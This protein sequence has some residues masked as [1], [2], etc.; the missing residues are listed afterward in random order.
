MKFS[1]LP[2]LLKPFVHLGLEDVVIS[3]QEACGTCP[4]CGKSKKFYVN[5]ATGQW[6]CKGGGCARSGNLYT[7]LNDWHEQQLEDSDGWPWES[8]SKNRKLPVEVLQK[9]GLVAVDDAWFVPVYGSSGKIVTYRSFRPDSPLEDLRK[10]RALPGLSLCL[11]GMERLA[12][13]EDANLPVYLCEGEWD[14]IALHDTFQKEGVAAVVVAAP[15][16]SVFKDQWAECFKGREVWLCYDNDT[17][18]EKGHKRAVAALSAY[19]THINRI[20][21]PEACP[22]GYDVRDFLS[23]GASLD[24]FQELFVPEETVAPSKN[25]K[26][27]L[28]DPGRP[29]FSDALAV[30]KKWLYMTPDMVDA[31]RIIYAVVLSNQIDGDPLWIHLAGPPGTGKTELLSS[32][33]EVSSCVLRS[34]VTAHA[35]VSGFKASPDP[36]LIPKLIGKVFML[37]DFTEILN[38]K[39]DS[40]DFIYGVLRG[41]YDGEVRAP[42]GNGIERHYVGYFS[43]VTGVTQAIFGE[44]GTSLGER[45]LI[46]HMTKGV[47]WR[48]D[49]MI[50]SAVGNV[51]DETA[52]KAAL[53]GA[54]KSFLEVSVPK[55]LVPTVP[56][57]YLQKIVALAQLV[58]MLRGGVDRDF[59]REYIAYRPQHEVGTRIAKQLKKLILSLSLLTDS[60]KV[61]DDCYQLTKR[62]AIDTCG[63]TFSLEILEAL[64]ASSGLGVMELFSATGVPF[65]TLRERLEDMVMLGVLRKETVPSLKRRGT[66]AVLYHVSDVVREYWCEAMVPAKTGGMTLKKLKPVVSV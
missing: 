3:G 21:W 43:M 35:L 31:L 48:S 9:A 39:K 11:Y 49:D 36:S 52:M 25:G 23:D 7:F 54:A 42:F 46:Y 12:R 55:N 24:I 56:V 61:D 44:R 5:V 1:N 6:S 65:S 64:V 27:R 10:L 45:F 37:K 15:G 58:A 8:L 14:A 4:F 30:Y 2:D 29:T 38:M 59:S 13:D 63:S 26:A 53:K 34:T 32:C 60:G 18:G 51:G 40:K 50:L 19:T 16:A 47:G 41:A 66:S 17:A 22:E 33:S 28:R 62:V 57:L 20:Q